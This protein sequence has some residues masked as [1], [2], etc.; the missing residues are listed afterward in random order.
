MNLA[1]GVSS[2]DRKDWDGEILRYFREL[3]GDASNTGPD[4]DRRLLALQAE[5]QAARVDLGSKAYVKI[6]F[7]FVVAVRNRMRPGTQSGSDGIVPEMLHL[8]SWEALT[9]I[10]RAFEARL[11]DRHCVDVAPD[12]WRSLVL[13]CIA[14]QPHPDHPS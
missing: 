11:N 5:A 13:Y 1:D 7:A 14:K 10:H 9:G 8:L 3:F 12:S 6:P 2:A 4:Q